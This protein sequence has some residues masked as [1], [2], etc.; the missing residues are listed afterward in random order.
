MSRSRNMIRRSQPVREV[1]RPT[2]CIVTDNTEAHLPQVAITTA[3]SA[4]CGDMFSMLA[5]DEI[6]RQK[7]L[8]SSS[9]TLL[10]PDYEPSQRVHGDV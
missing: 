10:F 1:K 5:V 2:G 4:T 3:R 7:V 8:V 9:E 6:K